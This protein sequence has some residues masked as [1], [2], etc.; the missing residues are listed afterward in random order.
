MLHQ[1]D[2]AKLSTLLSDKKISSVE[3][4]NHF[5]N[6]IK[7]Y[8]AELNSFIHTDPEITI[9]Q[10]KRADQLRAKGNTGPLCGIPIAQK[11]IFTTTSMPTTCGS[12]MLQGYISPFDADLVARSYDAGMVLLGKTNMDEFAMGGANTNSFF[13]D[14][15]NPWNFDHVPGG[16]SGGSSSCVA[17]R[18]APCASG[19]DTG[20]SIRQPAA[21]TGIT[22][23][24]PTY[25]RIP[26]WGMVA[27]SSSLDQGGPMALSA[28]DAALLLNAWCGH[29][30]NDFTSSYMKTIDFTS[31]I[32]KSI[33]GMKIGIPSEF[34][35]DGLDPQVGELVEN[36]IKEI[37]KMGAEIV[38]VHIEHLKYCVPAYY[39]IAPSEAS[40]NLAKF[41]GV[42]YGYRCSNPTSLNDLYCRTR[43]EGFGEEVKR[44]V[45]VGTFAMSSEYNDMFY[46]KAQAVRQLIRNDFI[47]A[48]NDVDALI[49]PTT[50]TPAFKFGGHNDNPVD[51]YKKDIYTIS[52]NLAGI[53]AISVPCGFANKLPVGMQI[54][55]NRFDESTL[56]RIAH[57]YQQA[58]D[59]HQQIPETYV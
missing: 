23:I 20:G 55:A 8:D 38:E 9:A 21:Y 47:K 19:T 34:F 44:R 52:A 11:D 40:S 32:N 27:F 58:T 41:D 57:Q 56:L 22:G 53:P 35:G 5:L 36:A 6:R 10:A 13:G 51:M 54:M 29:S 43:E 48:F 16:S 4:A 3:L 46:A 17:A 24:K 49:S 37:E 15:K 25:G 2:I 45:L 50:T 26:R 39:I 7:T 18:L 30:D 33:K 1:Y 42:R 31:D 12:K 59:W 28:Y 14:V